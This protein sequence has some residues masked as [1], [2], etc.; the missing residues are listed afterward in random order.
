MPHPDQRYVEAL[1]ANDY[2]VIEKLYSSC[3]PQIRRMVINNNGS[4]ADAADLFQDAL[5]MICTRARHQHF[6]LTCPMEA[7]LYL[8]CK[9]RW[10]NEL[11]KKRNKQV[12]IADDAGFD[13]GADS[14]DA[15]ERFTTLEQRRLLVE[16]MLE[17]LEE[18]CRQLLRLAWSGRSMEEIAAMLNFSYAYVRKKKSGCMAKL[19]ALVRSSQRYADLKW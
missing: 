15:Y 6:Q 5:L 11:H 12:T 13:I 17:H 7:F 1:L 14:T 2:G 19:V 8:V 16:S 18:G 9:N 4:E 10:I 3:W